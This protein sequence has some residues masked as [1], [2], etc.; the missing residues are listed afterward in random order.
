M[1]AAIFGLIG[2]LVGGLL[3]FCGN[4]L[5]QRAERQDRTRKAQ[6]EVARHA[7]DERKASYIRVLAAARHLRY[8]ARAGSIIDSEAKDTIDSLKAELS[9]AHYE[10]E[11]ISPSDIRSY[12]DALRRTVLDY[13]DLAVSQVSVGT[14][15]VQDSGTLATQRRAT[16]KSVDTFIEKARDD[17]DLS[18][19]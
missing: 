11:L 14:R 15:V 2:T 1:S 12:S 10:I 4:W 8:R 17:L 6:R 13:I 19:T 7:R 18:R 5:I 16:R 9:T 3:A